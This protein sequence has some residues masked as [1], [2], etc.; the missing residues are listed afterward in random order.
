[1]DGLTQKAV[2]CLNP[3]TQLPWDVTT[4]TLQKAQQQYAHITERGILFRLVQTLLAQC[5]MSKMDTS[6][7]TSNPLLLIFYLQV[8]PRYTWVALSGTPQLLLIRRLLVRLLVSGLR[9]WCVLQQHVHHQWVLHMVI[10]ME[11]RRST[12]MG[13][14]WYLRAILGFTFQTLLKNAFVFSK[15]L[16]AGTILYVTL[17]NAMNHQLQMACLFLIS[18]LNIVRKLKII[19]QELGKSRRVNYMNLSRR[20]NFKPTVCIIDKIILNNSIIM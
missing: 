7:T 17:F 1:M 18:L 13:L 11:L 19:L 8:D 6:I 4:L 20:R 10:I 16:G 14:C 15:T 9:N 5:Q 3:A 12:Y 2:R